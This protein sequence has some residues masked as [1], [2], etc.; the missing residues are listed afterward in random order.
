MAATV[1]IE[2]HCNFIFKVK[3]IAVNII[4][5]LTF[6]RRALR[7]TLLLAIFCLVT[8][9]TQDTLQTR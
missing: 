3:G 6:N 2:E 7:T 9:V 1:E 8:Q 4:K 5:L